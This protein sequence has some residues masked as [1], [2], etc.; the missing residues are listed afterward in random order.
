MSNITQLFEYNVEK[1][2]FDCVIGNVDQNTFVGRAHI[3]LSDN[4]WTV[5]PKSL[6]CYDS[7]N[8]NLVDSIPINGYPTYSF[9]QSNGD[10]WLTGNHSI[11]IFDTRTKKR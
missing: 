10:L 1:N 3:D 6:R 5:N 9:M 8:M 7:S 4:L 2:Q 11:S